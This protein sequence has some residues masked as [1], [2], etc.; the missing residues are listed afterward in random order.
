MSESNPQDLH[1]EVDE[2]NDAVI[3]RA[4][5]LSLLVLVVAA[6]AIGAVIWL[7][8]DPEVIVIDDAPPPPTLDVREDAIDLPSI[9]FSDVT[10]SSGITFIHESG[11]AGE[12]LLPESMGGGVAVLD[13]DSDGDQDIVFVNGKRWPWEIDKEESPQE[14][15]TMSAWRNDGDLKFTEVTKEVGLDLSFYGMGA[16]VGDYDADGDPDIYLTAVG[17]NYLLRNEDGRFVDATKETANNDG[18][19]VAGDNETWS[20]SAGFFDY[21]ND[22]DLDLFVCNYVV[23]NREFDL[24]QPFQLVGDER[25]YGRPAVFEGTFPYLF[26]N[27]GNGHF[28]DVSESAGIQIRNPATDVPVAKSLGVTFCDFDEDGWLDI[29]VANDTVQNF[30]FHNKADGSFEEIGSGVGIA[31]DEDG[32]ARGA[33]GID[34][35]WFRNDGSIGIAIGNF[36]TEMTALYV[37]SA[38]TMQ[39]RDDAVPTGLGPFTRLELTFGVCWSDFDLDGHLDLFAANGHLENDI[40]RVQESQQ[41]EQPPQLFWNCG[42]GSLTE[43]VPLTEE[44]CGADFFRRMVGR[45]AVTA[46]FD[47]DGDSDILI[48]ACGQKP[49]LLR[50]DQQSGNNWVRLEI[51]APIGTVVE[52]RAGEKTQKQQIMPTRSYLSQSES[53]LTFGLGDA[54]T[55]E[56]I[57]V[58]RPSPDGEVTTHSDLAVN[59]LHRL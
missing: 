41:Y 19:G 51:D 5:R 9:P 10:D 55:I 31:F 27:D 59:Q 24:A 17:S 14:P 15:A 33:M 38:G 25:A 48:A 11:A 28:K 45:G 13:F 2:Q 35:G 12:K 43:F 37:S 21:D 50:N 58:R 53:A 30:L 57:V 40:H 6:V 49:R 26:R 16:A 3:G 42:P 46:D 56:E 7:N 1:E 32:R 29:A 39:F 23:W 34:A 36:A 18:P 47:L 22:G 54:E 20:T 4:F 52:V 8:R 44:Q